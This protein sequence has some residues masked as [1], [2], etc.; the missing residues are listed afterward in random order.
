MIR[1]AGDRLVPEE[2]DDFHKAIG[3]LPAWRLWAMKQKTEPSTTIFYHM[4]NKGLNGMPE[5]NEM[6]VTINGP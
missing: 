1:D 2:F 6:G 4:W 3:F 5:V